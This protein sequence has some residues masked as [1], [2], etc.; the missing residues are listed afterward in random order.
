[1]S[2]EWKLAYVASL[3]RTAVTAYGVWTDHEGAL[4]PGRQEET[5]SLAALIR[6]L[7]DILWMPALKHEPDKPR[8]GTDA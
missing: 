2:P 6:G 1:M 3:L 8:M 7:L 4:P 5:G